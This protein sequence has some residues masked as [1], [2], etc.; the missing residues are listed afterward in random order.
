MDFKNYFYYHPKMTIEGCVYE[1]L[2]RRE[3]R[4]TGREP[5]KP[6]A[7]SEFCN[8]CSARVQVANMAGLTGGV[9]QP[10]SCKQRASTSSTKT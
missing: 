6:Q 9:R 7:G 5:F 3:D 4:E 2:V 1:L 10:E 8:A